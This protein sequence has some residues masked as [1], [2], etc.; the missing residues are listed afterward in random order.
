MLRTAVWVGSNESG[1]IIG[2]I[3]PLPQDHFCRTER[4]RWVFEPIQAADDSKASM[5]DN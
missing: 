1:P 2:D 4:N 3:I 5:H